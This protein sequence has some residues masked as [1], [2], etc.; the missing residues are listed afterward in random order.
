MFDGF[1]DVE[2]HLFPAVTV[3][4]P[5]TGAPAAA[6]A[7]DDGLPWPQLLTLLGVAVLGLG[8]WAYAIRPERPP[9]R[10]GVPLAR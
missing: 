8:G 2:P 10:P 9:R 1:T 4:P 5:A 7:A 3:A 6:G